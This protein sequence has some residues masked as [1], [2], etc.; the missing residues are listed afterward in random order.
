[1]N[2]QKPWQLTP[3]NIEHG[4]KIITG[5]SAEKGI[6]IIEHASQKKLMEYLWGICDTHEPPIRFVNYCPKMYRW[7]CKL[8]QEELIK[9]FKKISNK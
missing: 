3:E 6:K 1:M 2:E 7:G 4:V 9:Y 5:L 8:C